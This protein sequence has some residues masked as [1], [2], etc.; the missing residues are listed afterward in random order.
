MSVL[1][2]LS[3]GSGVGSF[4]KKGAFR[5][6]STACSNAY[7]KKGF[8][9]QARQQQRPQQAEEEVRGALTPSRPV[10]RLPARTSSTHRRHGHPGHTGRHRRRCSCRAAVKVV[11]V[12]PPATISKAG[13]VE[14][15]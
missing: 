11:L 14:R 8:V 6:K 15:R 9:A 13:G 7:A 3:S 2:W 5:P 4:W 12:R 1:T 10:P